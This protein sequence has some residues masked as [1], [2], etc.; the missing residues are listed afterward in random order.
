M[1]TY[2]SQ[3]DMASFGQ[4]LLSEERRS[5]FSQHPDLGNSNLEE[6][7][8]KVHDSDFQNWMLLNQRK[9]HNLVSPTV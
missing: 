8:S 7:L 5:L 1:I 6:R 4:Y 3:D 9:S 2:Y